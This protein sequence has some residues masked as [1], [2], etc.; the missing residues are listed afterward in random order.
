MLK[1]S[2]MAPELERLHELGYRLPLNDAE[3][4]RMQNLNRSW[5]TASGQTTERF[6]YE[7]ANY[8]KPFLKV[9]L[10]CPSLQLCLKYP[11]YVCCMVTSSKLQSF[12]LQQQTFLEKCE[13]WME[14]LVQTEENL[15]VEISGNYQSLMEQQKAHEVESL[16][17]KMLAE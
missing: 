16:Y 4:K 7:A 10:Q 9:H 17:F 2:S 5:S 12:L 11:L 8:K 1:F 6:R 14:F 3:I 15:A 13:T